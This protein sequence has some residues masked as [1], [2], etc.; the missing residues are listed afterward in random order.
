[1]STAFPQPE[2]GKAPR[3]GPLK[4]EAGKLREYLGITDV[5][6]VEGQNS[7]A[8]VDSTLV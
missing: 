8:I 4:V 2:P 1:M 7:L 5:N 3:P 6:Y